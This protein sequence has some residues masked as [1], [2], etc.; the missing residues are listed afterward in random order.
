MRY[1][2]IALGSCVLACLAA[3]STPSVVAPQSDVTR[4]L[5]TADGPPK[6]TLFTVQA[7]RDGS[8]A[9]SALMVSGAHRALFDPAG[10]FRHPRA[11]ERNDV[12][13]GITDDVKAVYI[14]YHARQTYDIRIQELEVSPAVAALALAE[15]ESYGPVPQAFCGRSVSTILSRLPGFEDIRTSFFPNRISREFGNRS[16]VATRVVTDDDADDNHGV[17]IVAAGAP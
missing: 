2:Q 11:P 6:I 10:T 16:G 7:T 13:Y 12:L 8:G 17:L 9:H 3:C 4:A 5:F 15:I 14:D 1:L